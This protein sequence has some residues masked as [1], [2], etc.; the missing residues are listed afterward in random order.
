MTTHHQAIVGSSAGWGVSI[1]VVLTLLV[2]GCNVKPVPQTAHGKVSVDGHPR[3]GIEI[4]FWDAAETDRMILSTS[5]SEDGT[6]AVQNIDLG[7][8][9]QCVVTFS[10]PALKNGDDL[11]SDMK[12][13]AG[14]TIDLVPA[15]LR[16]PKESN[17]RT[18]LPTS[19]FQYDIV[20]TK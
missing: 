12:P 2:S 3:G 11:P 20:T 13:S 6:F 18:D 1:A 9:Q 8:T 5:T 14:S 19:D 15:K 4:T 10:K 7:G 17:V 16:S